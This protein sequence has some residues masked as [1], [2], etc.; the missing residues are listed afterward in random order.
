M[1]N[2]NFMCTFQIKIKSLM[3]QMKFSG[4]TKKKKIKHLKIEN[5]ILIWN[6]LNE[7]KNVNRKYS[8]MYECESVVESP[9]KCSLFL[10]PQQFFTEIFLPGK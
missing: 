3:F 4:F 5:G 10:F 6:A 2:C 9:K 8:G 1:N 7:S